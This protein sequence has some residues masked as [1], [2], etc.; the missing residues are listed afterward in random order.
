MRDQN[1]NFDK[2]LEYETGNLPTHAEVQYG[3]F[4]QQSRIFSYI[5]KNIDNF[6]YYLLDNDKVIRKGFKFYI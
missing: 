1:K 6:I 3:N 5:S 4:L 2:D